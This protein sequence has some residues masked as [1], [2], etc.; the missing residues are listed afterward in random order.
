M[1]E[2]TFAVRTCDVVCLS[3][4][5]PEQPNIIEIMACTST[6]ICSSLPALVDITKYPHLTDIELADNCTDQTNSI[7][8]LI[9]LNY[10]WSVS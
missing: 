9:G 10:Y 1:R 8:V 2:V 5:R 4:Q 3:L 6:I 7:N